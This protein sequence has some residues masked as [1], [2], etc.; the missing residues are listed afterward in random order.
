MARS[1]HRSHSCRLGQTRRVRPLA[2]LHSQACVLCGQ[3]LWGRRYTC[4]AFYPVCRDCYLADL[5]V[6]TLA[7][8]DD[9]PRTKQEE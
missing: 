3:V 5:P 9:I 1:P 7:A 6:Q 2:I 4:A 8:S